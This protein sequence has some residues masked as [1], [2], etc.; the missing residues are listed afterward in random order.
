M[1]SGLG[2]LF[3]YGTRRFGIAAGLLDYGFAGFALL[4]LAGV[5]THQLSLVQLL[6]LGADQPN[7]RLLSTPGVER[8]PLGLGFAK[9]QPGR[10][11]DRADNGGA[12]H[13]GGD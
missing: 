9:R 10:G 11:H 3:S 5:A 2:F 7:L 1:L 6:P 4:L 8:H 13:G 12:R